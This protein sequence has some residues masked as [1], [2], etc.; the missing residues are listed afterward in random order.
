LLPVEI[1]GLD[2]DPLGWGGGGDIEL[3]GCT[4]EGSVDMFGWDKGVNVETLGSELGGAVGLA[5]AICAGV[6]PESVIW[7]CDAIVEGVAGV[8][9]GAAPFVGGTS[10]NSTAKTFISSSVALAASRALT[11]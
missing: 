10:G 4:G 3:L 6:Q 2:V 1:G 11:L 8:K 5:I 9:G 7:G